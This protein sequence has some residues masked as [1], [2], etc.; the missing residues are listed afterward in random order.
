LQSKTKTNTGNIQIF[1]E[2]KNNFRDL[3]MPKKEY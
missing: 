2:K 1:Q 3:K